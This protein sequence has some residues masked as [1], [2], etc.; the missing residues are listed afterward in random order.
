MN[1]IQSIVMVEDKLASPLQLSYCQQSQHSTPLQQ[2]LVHEDTTKCHFI[3]IVPY[4]IILH[5][6]DVMFAYWFT[7]KV[8]QQGIIINNFC[9]S[10]TNIIRDFFGRL[11]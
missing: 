8:G 3:N 9:T 6:L 2:I 10:L 11:L 4:L 7:Y 1:P 5:R